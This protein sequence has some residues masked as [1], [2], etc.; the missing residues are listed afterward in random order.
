MTHPSVASVLPT[1]PGR[2]RTVV[3][4]VPDYCVDEVSDHAMALLLSLIR[5]VP[6]SNARDYPKWIP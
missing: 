1:E 6:F 3:T 4:K 5:K 2:A